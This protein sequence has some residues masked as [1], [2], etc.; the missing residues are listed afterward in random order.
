M[1]NI[2]LD[3]SRWREGLPLLVIAAIGAAALVWMI[4][5]A[6]DQGATGMRGSASV[7][8]EENEGI[9]T[10]QVANARN[11]LDCAAI[12]R[13]EFQVTFRDSL[14]GAAAFVS[15]EYCCPASAYVSADRAVTI[16]LD[17]DVSYPLAVS[18]VVR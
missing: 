9:C 10:V 4:L 1:T 7:V 2:R 3:R 11:V 5:T 12:S 15:T 8:L 13:D 17:P 6:S 14:E 16:E 18:V